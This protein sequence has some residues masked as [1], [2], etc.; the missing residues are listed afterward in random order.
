L[1]IV[2]D[3]SPLQYLIQIAAVELLPAMFARVVT[4]DYVIDELRHASAPTRVRSWTDTLPDWL[5]VIRP[6]TLIAGSLGVG[7]R[8]A[9]SLAMELRADA[10]LIDDRQA[11]RLAR[12]SGLVAFGTLGLLLEAD[13]QGRISFPSTVARLAVETNFYADPVLL[14]RLL[15]EHQNR[16]TL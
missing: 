3:T 8:S 5:E 2:S 12:S 11:Y 13:R 14:Q 6:N 9:I 1:I 16:K 7:E 10:V 4:T 15:V